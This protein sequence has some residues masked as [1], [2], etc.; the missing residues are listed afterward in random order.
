MENTP[1]RIIFIGAG[2]SLV[3]LVLVYFI[4]LPKTADYDAEKID[5][6]MEFHDSF[7]SGHE[8]GRK[9]W[10]F[11]ADRGWSGKDRE[12]T[13]FEGITRGRFFSS[14]EVIVKDLIA[15]RVQAR[16]SSK[17]IEAFGM[18]E[19][20]LIKRSRLRAVVAFT[21]KGKRKFALLTADHITYDPNAKR[22]ML[23][24]NIS[25]KD[26]DSDLMADHM[27]IDHEN[28][29]A[30][31]SDH[32]R[33]VRKELG[34]TSD[35]LNY[36]ARDERMVAGGHVRC[37]IAGKPSPTLVSCG[38]MEFYIDQGRDVNASGSLEVI[39]GKKAVVAEQMT[40]RN[41]A[42]EVILSGNVRTVIQKA[43]SIFK[44]GTAAKI[45]SGEARKLLAE[46][47]F[48]T[49]DSLTLSTRVGDA[50]AAGN[51]HVYQKGR[52]G[53]AEKA[54]YSDP[55]EILTLTGQVFLKKEKQWIK[56]QSIQVSVKNETFNA[57][58]SVEAE[59]RIKK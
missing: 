30:T 21:P 24:G 39:Q 9:V 41:P 20:D 28:E 45:K 48:I 57:V 59:F 7:F 46:K 22:S 51:V 26:K 55:S 19:N 12:V 27:T 1:W 17:L 50:V 49:S 53:K 32:I 42:K 58:G 10:E 15:P 29:V 14:G 43:G 38:L 25:L 16:K 6:I 8:N 37:R 52:E 44:P 40:Y 18:L 2:A 36:F 33:T 11:R 47:T 3:L 5:R 34:L 4:A 56:C 23:D 13:Y 54:S 31:L 35:S